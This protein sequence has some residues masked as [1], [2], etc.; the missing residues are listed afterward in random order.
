MRCRLPRSYPVRT[1]EVT[2]RGRLGD[3]RAATFGEPFARLSGTSDFRL[4]NG[5][6]R[7]SRGDG[8]HACAR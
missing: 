7:F 5:A 6:K 4:R 3:V 1:V 8:R 2:G